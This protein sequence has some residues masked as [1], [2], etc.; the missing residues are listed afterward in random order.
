MLAGLI[1]PFMYLDIYAASAQLPPL[2][3]KYIFWKRSPTSR[4]GIA[5]FGSADFTSVIS[6]W[7]SFG[8]SSAIAATLTKASEPAKKTAAPRFGFG[9]VVPFSS[10][11][12][13]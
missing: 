12:T 8:A 7:R 4:I 1:A 9:M 5:N 11:D 10:I 6:F 13:A 3:A 2:A